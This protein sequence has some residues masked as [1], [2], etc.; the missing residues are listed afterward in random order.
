LLTV[1]DVLSARVSHAQSSEIQKLNQQIEQMRQKQL[2]MAQEFAKTRGDLF[3]ARETIEQMKHSHAT[4]QQVF[5]EQLTQTKS[6]LAA[7]TTSSTEIKATNQKLKGEIT[8]LCVYFVVV[9]EFM[10]VL[11]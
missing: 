8:E 4:E 11:I 3:A 1:F 2:T 6:Q 10:T 5:I 9:K 7:L